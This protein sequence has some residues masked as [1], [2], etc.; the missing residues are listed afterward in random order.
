MTT[1]ASTPHPPT[2]AA[3]APPAAR[4]LERLAAVLERYAQAALRIARTATVVGAALAAGVE[5]FNVFTRYVLGY[6]LF[7]SDELARFGFIWTIWLGVALAVRSGAAMS[8]TILVNHGPAWWRRALRT[9]S[10]AALAA[11]LL[12][13]CYRATQ[14]VTSSE[15]LSDTSPALGMRQYYGIAPMALGLYFIALFYLQQAVAGAARL[16]A[17]GRAGARAALQGVVGGA[18]VAVLVWAG[19]YGLLQSGASKLVAL[20]LVF[21]ALTLAAT[22]VVFMLLMVGLVATF[23]LF[24]LHFYPNPDTLFPW[25]TIEGTIGLSGGSELLVILMFLV[26]AEVMNASG[27]SDRLIRFAAACVGH[28]RGGMA[29]VCQLTS[30][31]AS[32]ISGSAQADAAVMTPLLVPAMEKE[33]YP[34]DVAAAVVAGA[35]IKGPIG[36]ISIMFIVYGVVVQGPA[37]ASIKKLLLSGIFAEILLLLFQGAT[38]Y[39]VVRRM[40]FFKKRPFAGVRVVGRTALEALPVLAIPVI[41]LGGIL[42][43]VFTP[44]ESGAVAALVVVALALYWY[45]NLAPRELPGVIAAAGLETGIVMLLIGTSQVLA[46]TL[47]IQSFG[48]SLAT[49]F[50]FT[51]NKYVFLLVVNLLLLAVGIFIEPLPALYILAP[52]LAPIAVVGYGVD[53][54]H[55]GLIMV[56]NLVLALI[57]PPIGLV[58]FLVSSIAKVSIERL[59]IMILPWLG[60]SLVVLFLVTYL[61]SQVVLAL[62]NLVG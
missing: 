8:I 40:G 46:S 31:L 16:V 54:T 52:F 59:S 25:R 60:V 23:D 20:G 62:S 45:G 47:F 33:G 56:F 37:G 35:S 27:M 21:V 32:G 34:R 57:H 39:L 24:G 51:S 29:Y 36:P 3:P 5:A 18:V 49:F 26:V 44:T 12:F 2:P 13:A 1:V 55:F 61:P 10:G 22:P 48:D 15:S 41:I 50:D 43:G 58:L 30:A 6:S 14:Y 11:L 9:F 42:A 4:A 7:G 53:P 38:V 17:T 19:T 28:L